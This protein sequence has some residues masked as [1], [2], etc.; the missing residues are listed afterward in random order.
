MPRVLVIWG[1]RRW[2]SSA[3][4][5]MSSSAEP[6]CHSQL[7]PSFW[8][9]LCQRIPPLARLLCFR[10]AM[11]IR[12]QYE[13]FT[14][15]EETC[16]PK[17][18]IVTFYSAQVHLIKQTLR[19]Q[20]RDLQQLSSPA[21]TIAVSTVDGCQGSEADIV[22]ISFVRCNRERRVGFLKDRQRL[23]VALTRAKHCLLIVG[24]TATLASSGCSHL[25]LLVDD[26]RSRGV[27]FPESCVK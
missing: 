19:K 27:I 16:L 5:R 1:S 2:L 17:I 13:T 23:N 9:D 10:M 24:C 3:Y 11:R 15:T 18:L 12:A 7:L 25:K 20:Q 14:S 6:H 22:L 8:C 21:D 4:G 26:V